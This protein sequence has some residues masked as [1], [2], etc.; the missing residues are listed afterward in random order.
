[1]NL[2]LLVQK[3]FIIAIGISLSV[4]VGTLVAPYPI[5]VVLIVGVIGSTAT[6]IFGVLKIP[7]PA[8]IFFVLSFTMTTG[9][10]VDPSQAPI[11]TAVVLMSGCFSWIVSMIGY[12]V[13]PHGPEIKVIKEVYLALAAF[14][15]AI[16]SKNINN[17]RHR[18][19]D[20]LKES[21]DTLSIGYI[22]WKNS[23]LFNRLVLLNE[24]ANKLFL[25]M[26]ELYSNKNTKLPKDFGE[27]IRKLSMGVELKDGDSIEMTPLQKKRDKDYYNLLDTWR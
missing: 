24:Y 19:V 13:S 26:L 23:F 11:R 3:K 17:A 21:E 18:T 12:F 14:S 16:G 27:M 8:A 1:M 20:A 25:E 15:E 22:S 2:M 6:F 5:L 7:G 10:P 9:M 4:G